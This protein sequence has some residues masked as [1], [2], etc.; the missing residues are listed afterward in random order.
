M[1]NRQL[2][3][4]FGGKV[5]DKCLIGV[6]FFAPQIV[7]KMSRK[8]AMIQLFDLVELIERE[9]QAD[10]VGTTGNCNDQGLSG[11]QVQLSPFRY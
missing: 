7:I 8:E 3:I 6:A 1:A 5:P 4:A 9:Q 11:G 10:G 2:E